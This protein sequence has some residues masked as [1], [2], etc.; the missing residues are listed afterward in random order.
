MRPMRR[1]RQT[2]TDDDAWALF[3]R[4]T[5]VHLSMVHPEGWPML[6]VVHGVVVDG[7]LAFHG[8]PLGEKAEVFAEAAPRAVAGVEE[9]IAQ[10]P[11]HFIHPERA[12]PATTWYRSA[13]MHGHLEAVEDEAQ[14][15][16]ILQALMVRFQ[17]GGGHV[18]IDPALADYDRLYRRAVA[19][20]SVVRLVPD[21]LT[22]KLALG[23]KRPHLIPHIM[24]KLWRRGDVGDV[25][26]ISTLMQAYPKATPPE[27]FQGP[28]GITLD[29]SV[30][31]DLEDCLD[32]LRGQY[33]TANADDDA[34]R[35]SL[36]H[37]HVVGARTAEGN[38]VAIAAGVSEGVRH[39]W[40]CNVVVHPNWRGRGIGSALMQLLLDHPALR[41]AQR[42]GLSTRDA[43]AVYLPLGFE[44]GQVEHRPTGPVKT[45][46]RRQ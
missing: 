26:A 19:S 10:I 32:L 33:W 5:A 13:Q 1:P 15:A 18:P 25:E 35:H 34:L 4:S 22:A 9:I 42:V 29:P 41:H 43:E 24:G 20:L 30:N 21:R 12:C 45:L 23:Q 14:K 39:G 36:R 27:I 7:A 2:L 37:S 31:A 40:I 3:E 38:L 16:R 28:E 46:W 8:S 6:K 11:S 44:I 17:A